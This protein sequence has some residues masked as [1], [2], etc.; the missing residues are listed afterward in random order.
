MCQGRVVDGLVCI[1]QIVADQII[2]AHDNLI[3]SSHSPDAHKVVSRLLF[4]DGDAC[5]PGIHT[6]RCSGVGGSGRVAECC[7]LGRS[8][9]TRL[10]SW[11]RGIECPFF[12]P[13][14]HI[15]L[16]LMVERRDRS[17][18][19]GVHWDRCILLVFRRSGPRLAP[20]TNTKVRALP[21]PP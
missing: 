3:L 14:V 10:C 8:F 21:P 1:K 9:K 6:C 16:L 5:V 15:Q 18:W 11:S 12:I 4:S 2:L 17:L 19:A 13:H 20:K 7:S